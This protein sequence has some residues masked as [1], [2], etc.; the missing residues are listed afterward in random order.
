MEAA[1]WNGP[2]INRT[3]QRLGLRSEASARFE[4][5]LAPEQAIEAQAVADAADARARPAR[6]S[7]PGTIDVG[8]AGPRA[9]TSC[10]CATRASTRLLGI[11]D[12]RA[13]RRPRSSSALGF[14]VADAGDGLDVTVPHFRRND[15]TR[16]ADLIEE[17]ARLDGLEKLPATL[18][19]G[20]GATACSTPEQRLRRRAEDALVGR[21]LHEVVGWSFTSAGGSTAELRAGRP[22]RDVVGS[23]PDERGPVGPAHDAARLA[24]RRRRATTSRAGTRTLRL[25]EPGAVYFD[26]PH[27]RELTAAE[28]RST[29]LP[30]ERTHLGAL[31]TGRVRP[32]SWGDPRR[33]RPTSSPPRACS[34][35][36]LRRA[37]RAVATV[38]R[39]AE[40]FLHPGRARARA[41]ARART[42]RLARRGAPARR[43]A[44]GTSSAPSR[45]FELDLGGA[46]AHAEVAPHYEDLTTFPP[47]RQDLAFVVA[48]GR[49]R[50][51]ERGRRR[52]R[53]GRRAAAPTSRSS[54]STRRAGGEGTSLALRLEF[55][56]RRPHA[57]RR[58]GRAAAREDRRGGCETEL[59]ASSWLSV[60]VL[61]ARRAT[62]ARSPRSCSTA[63]RT[64]SSRP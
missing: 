29:P 8:G 32:P 10:G 64:S 57:D 33:R 56:R 28:A 15:V 35:R 34:R 26:R 31:L 51:A 48:G 13:A 60:A 4:K 11:A 23:E 30:D 12:R 61:G 20:N 9:P 43:R 50:A 21:G 6:G 37:A 22:R 18:P 2:N 16:E 38:V 42:R 44:R 5:G 45:R 63:T 58:G 14:G 55:R 17:V 53:R 24:A 27:G 36:V 25:F 62:P 54:T 3:S 52:A 46:R 39:G 59:G 19:R 7:R 47:V 41:R 49:A 40:P 1:T